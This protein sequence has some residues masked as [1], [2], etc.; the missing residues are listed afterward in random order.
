MKYII[1]ILAIILGILMLVYQPFTMP[2]TQQA[3]V[4]WKSEAEK[5][6][7][8]RLLKKHGLDRKISCIYVEGKKRYFINSRGQKCK[9]I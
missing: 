3:A 7:F 5:K 8:H 6:E 2:P 1:L 9:F 4:V